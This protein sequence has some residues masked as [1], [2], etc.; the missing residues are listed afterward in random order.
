[1]R[2]NV[3]YTAKC[4]Q[5]DVGVLD[6]V[7]SSLHLQYAIA[8]TFLFFLQIQIIAFNSELYNNLSHAQVSSNGIVIISLL[9]QVRVVIYC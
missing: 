7:L 5:C 8:S 3:V 2:V 1:M 6:S 9:A 4:F